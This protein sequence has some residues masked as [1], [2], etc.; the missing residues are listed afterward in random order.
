M[1]S[2]RN[3]TVASDRSARYSADA[4]SASVASIEVGTG[5]LGTVTKRPF[6]TTYL[7]DRRQKGKAWAYLPGAA[8]VRNCAR[9]SG[10]LRSGEPRNPEGG[11]S[12]LQ[13][14]SHH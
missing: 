4:S 8:Q 2:A 1:R 13:R 6:D 5:D 12:P 14:P 10:A 3:S 11:A 7:V 9:H